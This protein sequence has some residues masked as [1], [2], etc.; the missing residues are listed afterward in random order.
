[1]LEAI[2]SAKSVDSWKNQYSKI[3]FATERTDRELLGR[4]VARYSTVFVFYVGK[5]IDHLKFNLLPKASIE[6]FWDALWLGIRPF[7]CFMVQKSIL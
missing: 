3:K 6:S 1:M 5:D 2:K 4:P 7:L